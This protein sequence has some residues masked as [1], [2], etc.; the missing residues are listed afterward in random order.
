VAGR[1]PFG[2]RVPVSRVPPVGGT[3]EARYAH[4][5][6][7]LYGALGVRWAL[8]QRRL[9]PSD[10]SDPRIPAGGTPGYAVLDVRAGYRLEHWLR[11]HLVLE[12]LLD[13]AY[14]VHGSSV[15]GPGRGLVASGVL[16]Y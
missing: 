13:A 9:A 7:G 2:A 4:E 14:R 3:V 5:P 12:N 6:S 1:T 16:S 8:H 15:N 10:L 11:L